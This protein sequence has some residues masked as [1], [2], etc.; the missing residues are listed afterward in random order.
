[1]F[2]IRVPPWPPWPPPNS[3]L[4]TGIDSGSER[5]LTE[6]RLVSAFSVD[7]CM[8]I[9]G[10]HPPWPPHSRTGGG[11]VGTGIDRIKINIRKD[12]LLYAGVLPLL[13]TMMA[14]E[15]R[16]SDVPVHRDCI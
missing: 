3:E 4:G 15:V 10:G 16:S 2:F 7:F 13:N 8:S 14:A 5:F 12:S 9:S 1:M 6:L 11:Q